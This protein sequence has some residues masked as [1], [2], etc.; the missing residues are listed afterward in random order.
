MIKLKEFPRFFSAIFLAL[1]LIAAPLV[2]QVAAQQAAKTQA[3][4][5][6]A[7]T[8]NDAEALAAIE[9]AIDAR[10]KELGIPGLS[11]VIVKDD[12]V[13][14]IKGLGLKDIDKKLPVTPDTLFAIG[15]ASKA[16]TAMA[17]VMSADEGKLSLE[18]SP[19]KF[20]PYFTLRDQDAAAKIT[21]RDLLSH[22]SGLNRTDLAMVTNMLNREELIKVAGRAKP[23]NKLGEKFQYQNVMYAAAGEVV[24]QAQHSTWDRVMETKI[25]KPLGMKG[26]NTTAAAMQKARDYSL[27][28]DYNSSTKVTRQ[29]PQREIPAAAPA[30]AINS[31][32]RDM[33]QWLRFMLAGGTIDGKRLVS[34]K[35][36][37]ETISK[38]M[39]IA[40]SVSYGLGWFLREW[41]GHKVVEHGGN[42]DGF[43]S[44]VALMPD[45][46]LGFVLLT[47]VT[48]SPL[49]AFAMNTVWK[50]LVGEPKKE[51]KTEQ[52]TT[53]TVAGPENDLKAEVG[54]YNLAE[55]NVNFDVA[56]K[57]G[58]LVLSVPGQPPYPLESLGGRRYKLGDP[59]PAG[60]FVT[61][62]PVK[63]KESETEM[64][65]EQP[66]GDIVAR[67]V[68]AAAAAATTTDTGLL[69]QVIGSYQ[70]ESSNN[71]IEIGERDGKVSLVVPGQ[72]P[73]ALVESEKDKLRSPGLPEAY[74]IEVKRDEKGEVSSIVLNQ[75]EGRFTLRRLKAEGSNKLISA[76]DLIAKMIEAYGGE[77]NLRKHKSSVSRIEIDMESQGLTG[78]GV[79]KAKAPNQV[80]SEMTITA[81]DKK[82]GA[83]VSYFDGNAGGEMMTFGPEEIYSGKRLEDIKVGADFYDV[84]DWKK[85]YAAITVK[86]I[87]KVGD[88]EAY[89]VEKRSEKGT[90]VTDY[91]SVKTFLLLKRESVIHSDT[92]GVDIPTSET[93]SDYRNVDGV[94]VPF[95][96]VSSNIANGDIVVLVKELKFDVDIPDTAF[97]K[98]AKPAVN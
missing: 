64:F 1:L 32:A 78:Y 85:N 48:G 68:P 96:S 42:I 6:A 26:S 83:V 11:L 70:S 14:Y 34:E 81:L 27:G 77:A 12:R 89:V 75:P 87:A 98:P 62:R 35:G 39:N 73:Y 4:A 95:K 19:K 21:L 93:F 46:K 97:S 91:I 82:I 60:F 69:R 29:L 80:A 33:A 58:K 51:Q 92:T 57:D 52:K 17:A 49:G 30:G 72:P 79:M 74:W 13:I 7:S 86:R 40:G 43:N 18:D 36:F 56:L 84:L 50:N 37:N 55:A 15:S 59:A 44:Q 10:R 5:A 63:D 38:Q 54:T 94:M 65:L 28:Y 53:E 31:S 3:T 8:Q 61:F 22:R 20:L 25:F 41:N 66:Q 9:T 47:N 24:A 45:Q 71:V 88:E 16:F 2:P 90:P 76:D 23:T 67:K